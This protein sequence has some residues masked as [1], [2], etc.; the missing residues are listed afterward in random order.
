MQV[1]TDMLPAKLYGLFIAMPFGPMSLMCVHRTMA[2][3]LSFGLASGMGAL[4]HERDASKEQTV[5]LDRILF[6]LAS[7]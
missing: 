5:M 7:A 2:V 3:G 1:L 4:G 6:S